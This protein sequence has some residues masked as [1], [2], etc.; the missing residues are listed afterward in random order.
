MQERSVGFVESLWEKHK[1]QT[2]LV[3]V[4]A[5]VIRGLVSYFLGLPYSENLKRKVSHCYIGDFLFNDSE[6]VSYNELGRASGF[7]QDEVISIPYKNNPE[8]K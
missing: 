1:D 2:I 5:G 6:C 7:V 3:V 8:N 4:H